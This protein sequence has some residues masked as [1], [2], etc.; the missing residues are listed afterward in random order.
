MVTLIFFATTNVMTA[1]VPIHSPQ[2]PCNLMITQQQTA[3]QKICNVQDMILVSQSVMVRTVVVTAARVLTKCF[4]AAIHV[5]GAIQPH[6]SPQLQC[7]LMITTF[8]SL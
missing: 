4:F 8:D 2:L 3:R 7:N 1:I 5:V 6:Y